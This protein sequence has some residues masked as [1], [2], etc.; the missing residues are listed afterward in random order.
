MINE[1]IDMFQPVLFVGCIIVFG[2]VVYG[3]LTLNKEK[4][5]RECPTI[6]KTEESPIFGPE[7]SME[8]PWLDSFEEP[9]IIAPDPNRDHE[10]IINL[11][12]QT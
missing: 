2:C 6:F 9:P 11:S 4:S 10:E 12:N 3:Y 7:F 8:D 5:A 1:I